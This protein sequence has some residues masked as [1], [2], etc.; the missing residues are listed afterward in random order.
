M[1]NAKDKLS[2][3]SSWTTKGGNFLLR[4]LGLSLR[5]ISTKGNFKQLEEIPKA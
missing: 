3:T 1:G 4:L 2:F 5:L